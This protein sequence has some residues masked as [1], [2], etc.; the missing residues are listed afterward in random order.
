M[1]VVADGPVVVVVEVAVVEVVAG[2]EV[3]V[4]VVVVVDVAGGSDVVVVVVVAADG[5]PGGCIPGADPAPKDQPSTVPGA[6]VRIAAPTMLN[7]QEPPRV[8][9]Q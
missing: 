7:D 8:A 3:V 2:A 6:G 1:D 4:V 9:D 5:S